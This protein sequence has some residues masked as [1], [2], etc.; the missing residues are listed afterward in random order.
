VSVAIIETVAAIAADRQGL[1]ARSRWRGC[2]STRVV[3]A[4]IV[5]VTK[6]HHLQDAISPSTF[7]L[8]RTRS[9]GR[10]LTR[11]PPP[12][13]NTAQSN[14]LRRGVAPHGEL[15]TLKQ[16]TE[17]LHTAWTIPQLF[18]SWNAYRGGPS[19]P[20]PRLEVL[21][22]IGRSTPRSP[23]EQPGTRLARGDGVK[24]ASSSSAALPLAM[25]RSRD[26]SSCSG[27]RSSTCDRH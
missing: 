16:P 27:S 13:P 3:S 2:L 4:P 17:D 10:K 26:Q 5:G 18:G 19:E 11:R 14:A 7:T 9:P 20:R 1:V 6:P 12:Q 23:I 15:P 24:A 21:R 22:I 8:P 25:V